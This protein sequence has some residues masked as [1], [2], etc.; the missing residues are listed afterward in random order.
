MNW[1]EEFK[2]EYRFRTGIDWKDSGGDDEDAMKYA[3]YSPTEAVT[4]EIQKYGLID[5]AKT[6]TC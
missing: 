4:A 6:P 3:N 2:A 1:L 5:L